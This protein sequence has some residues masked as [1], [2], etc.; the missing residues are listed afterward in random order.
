LAI[1][2]DAAQMRDFI[3]DRLDLEKVMQYT[4][5]QY[6]WDQAAA[7]VAEARYRDFLLVCW[8]WSRSEYKDRRV[9]AISALADQVWHCHMLLPVEYRGDCAAIFGPGRILD[10]TPRFGGGQVD[11]AEKKLVDWAYREA[12]LSTPTDLKDECVWPAPG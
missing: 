11:P 7:A 5:W 2:T 1:S 9:S 10:H 6:G 4:R 3:Y 8:T 12:G